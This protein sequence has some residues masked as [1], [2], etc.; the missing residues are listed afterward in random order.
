[1]QSIDKF[2]FLNCIN[3]S[4]IIVSP[5]NNYFSSEDGVLFNKSQDILITFPAKLK[6]YTIPET[7]RSIERCAFINCINLQTLIIGNSVTEI[8]DFAFM[9]CSNLK[10][11]IISNSVKIL[12]R[13]LFGIAINSNRL[14]LERH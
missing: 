2:P 12:Q 11:V 6:T 13:L 14:S 7:V 4:E 3:L 8:P 5:D 10:K 9:G 1:M